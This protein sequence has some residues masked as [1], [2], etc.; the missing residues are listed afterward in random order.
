[1]QIPDRV[2]IDNAGG[3]SV[4]VGG[5]VEA[6]LNAALPL[7]S[8]MQADSQ[9]F[10]PL[11]AHMSSHCCHACLVTTRQAVHSLVCCIGAS[12]ARVLLRGT[13]M[14]VW[15]MHVHEVRLSSTAQQH[16][17]GWAWRA[18]SKSVRRGWRG[19]LWA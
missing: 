14:Q 2:I 16:S 17:N 1:M 19:A 13:A 12:F 7:V 9:S 5:T 11:S 8:V 4:L 3:P 6:A 10:M 15:S 18:F